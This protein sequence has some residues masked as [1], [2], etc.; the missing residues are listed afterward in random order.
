MKRRKIS[1]L[2]RFSEYS[3]M[4]DIMVNE[5]GL[6][7]KKNK[8]TFFLN[9]DMGAPA[10]DNVIKKYPK[11][12][13][14]CGIS[15]QNMITV[16]SG[17]ALRGCNVFCYGMAPFVT[18]RCYEQLKI[19]L[20]AMNVPVC[21][22]GIGPGLGYADAGPTHYATEDL[23]IMAALPNFNILTAADDISCKILT[24]KILN[25]K[26]LTYFRIDRDAFPSVYNR[27][28]VK[29]FDTSFKKGF[30]E[31]IRG[32]DTCII[33]SGYLVHKIL[34]NG[35]NL[36][37]KKNYLGIVDLYQHSPLN[38]RELNKVIRRYKKIIIIDEQV[39]KLG[40]KSILFNEIDPSLLNKMK[41]FS[42]PNKFIF[43]NGGRDYL[44]RKNGIDIKEIL[45]SL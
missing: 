38:S 3:F 26:K 31:I 44:L 9:A 34:E 39:E 10:L 16:A 40:T 22:V 11:N 19:S 7:M 6:K 2:K 42:L 27:K 28:D 8:D 4:R 33:T 25:S 32:N 14:H 37:K 30:N 5:I 17:M 15:E 29:Y 20:S 43:E 24:K 45:K 36:I 13:V 35:Q 23:G 12:V 41:N 21:V 1:A 18:S